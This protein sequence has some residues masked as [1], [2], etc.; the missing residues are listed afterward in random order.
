[1]AVNIESARARYFNEAR[2]RY[3]LARR[4]RESGMSFAAVGLE[5]GVTRQRAAQLVAKSYRVA[6]E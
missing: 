6:A 3:D 2:K 5:L 4:L 1:M